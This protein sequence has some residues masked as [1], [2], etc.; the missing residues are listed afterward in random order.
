MR[1]SL[2]AFAA[3][4]AATAAFPAFAADA[5]AADKPVP[6]VGDV[7][8][9]AKTFVTIDCP[10]WEVAAVGKDG[11]NLLQCGEKTAYLD[12]TTATLAKIVAGDKRLVEFKPRS[13]TLSFPITVG[14]KWDGQYE[15]YR[16]DNGN[17]WKST[18]SCEAKA[19]ETIKVPA[20][21]FEAYR[22]QCADS[23]DAFPFH[24]VSDSTAWYAPK[25]GAVVKS[26]NPSQ[27]DFDYELVS[28]HVK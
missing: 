21:E 26:V 19:F 28:Y 22:I 15:G 1:R 12:A 10:R 8:E 2:F 16:A 3:M 18:V 13:P 23:W 9:Y 11:Y 17:A 27:S 6:N 5:P 20:G 4:A 14:K 24:G 25:L 7:F